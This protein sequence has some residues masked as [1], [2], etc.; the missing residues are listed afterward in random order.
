MS[1]IR[2]Q[3]EA[4]DIED[5][6]GNPANQVL[7]TDGDGGFTLS[8]G[9]GHQ[10][11]TIVIYDEDTFVGVFD[12]VRFIGAGVSVFN[13]GSYAAV[14]VTGSAA[15]P[16]SNGSG[17]IACLVYFTGGYMSLRTY[18]AN[19]TWE[20]DIYA[21]GSIT[22]DRECDI[23]I[24][25]DINFGSNNSSW[26]YYLF[27]LL[28]D[29]V[30]Q[31]PNG[32]NWGRQQNVGKQA[33]ERWQQHQSWYIENVASGTHVFVHQNQDGGSGNDRN[34]YRTLLMARAWLG[35]TKWVDF[36]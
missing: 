2:T 30:A 5:N 29:G 1:F 6:E 31:E 25:L 36:D 26:E 13:S 22:V 17:S 14:A 24:D 16:A 27:R 20:T 9:G 34:I 23:E 19:S 21:T 32:N 4:Q 8:A 3:I 15:A 33:N 10:T 28:F 11:G 12:E 18:T 35:G 7:V